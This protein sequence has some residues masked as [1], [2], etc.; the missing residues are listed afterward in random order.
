MLH[1]AHIQNYRSR[2]ASVKRYGKFKAMRFEWSCYR[3]ILS[4]DRSKFVCQ[5]EPLENRKLEALARHAGLVLAKHGQDVANDFVN[6]CFT[7][8]PYTNNLTVG[9]FIERVEFFANT[10]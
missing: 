7:A 5:S 2:T 9:L 4:F 8:L 6:R 3:K 1:I 10:H